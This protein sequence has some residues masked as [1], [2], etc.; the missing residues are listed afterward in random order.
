MLYGECESLSTMPRA[1]RD[2]PTGFFEYIRH[3]RPRETEKFVSSPGFRR[4]HDTIHHTTWID[5][6]DCW[7]LVVAEHVFRTLSDFAESM[8]TWDML[9]GISESIVRTYL[10]GPDFQTIQEQ[11]ATERDV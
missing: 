10:P 8:P 5:I 11:S 2:D 1:G 6:L 4:M 7:H 3:M 9:I